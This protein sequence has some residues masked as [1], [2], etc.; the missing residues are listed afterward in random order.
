MQAL[1][2]WDRGLSN[3]TI[4]TRR[5]RELYREAIDALDEE[6][7]KIVAELLWPDGLGPMPPPAPSGKGPPS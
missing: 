3:A 6:R 5:F 7:G 4:P 2:R 1:R